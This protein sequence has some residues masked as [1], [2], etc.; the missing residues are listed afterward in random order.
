MST[1][2]KIGDEKKTEYI[3]FYNV[4]LYNI[5]SVSQEKRDHDFKKKNFFFLK[6]NIYDVVTNGYI[7]LFSCGYIIYTYICTFQTKTFLIFFF[8]INA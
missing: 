6:T 3:N 7:K 2:N 4:I 1:V 8:Q 5:D